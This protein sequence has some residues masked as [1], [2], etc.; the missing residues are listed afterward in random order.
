MDPH[1][2]VY[3][4]VANS[5]KRDACPEAQKETFGSNHCVDPDAKCETSRSVDIQVDE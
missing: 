4:A 5:A 1:G 2:A 3:G